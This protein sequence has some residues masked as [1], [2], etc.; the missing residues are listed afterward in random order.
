MSR[1]NVDTVRALFEYWER[2]EWQASAELFDPEF[3][4][5]FSAGA[6][7]D[8]GTY[9]GARSTLDAWRNWLE[10]WEEFSLELEDAIPVGAARVVVLNRLRGRGK[11]SGIPV[12]SEVGCIFELDGGR[13]V[14]MTF[15]DRQEALDAAEPGER[16]S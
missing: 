7:P 9:R 2:G 11:T 16:R 4:A 5:I 1:E 13:I 10:A 15:C 14:R 3:E 6:F 8:P 12:D